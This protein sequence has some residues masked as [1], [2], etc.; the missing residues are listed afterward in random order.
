[1]I[2]M[3]TAVAAERI[4]KAL[5]SQVP[6]AA[7]RLLRIGDEVM[8]YK[9]ADRI[10]YS[11]YTVTSILGKQVEVINRLGEEKHFSLHQ[12]NRA[13][14]HK[15]ASTESVQIFNKPTIYGIHYMT[16]KFRSD[17]HLEEKVPLYATYI[18]EMITKS[19]PRYR[20]PEVQAAMRKEIE[21][22]VEK[23]T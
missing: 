9:E 4:S 13:P 12:V 6:P 7:D 18:S 15:H 11:G 5:K 17:Q 16:R 21:G 2:E 1:M 22:I 20:S 8:V 10:W 23:G 19:D 14:P 3:N